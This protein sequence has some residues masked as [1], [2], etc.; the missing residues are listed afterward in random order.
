[1][2]S[3][4]LHRLSPTPWF[5]ISA[6]E[7]RPDA[8]PRPNV[9]NLLES[10][11]RSFTITVVDAPSGFGK[12]TGLA[13]WAR[14][15]TA[16]T[17]WVTVV[18]DHTT[19][20]ELLSSVVA[21]LLEI[22]PHNSILEE[23][24]VRMQEGDEP[25]H[26]L[27]DSLMAALP[28]SETTTVILD[29]AHETTKE[30]LVAVIDPLVRYSRS[31]LRFVVA[32]T[33]DMSTW[34]AKQLANGTARQFPSESLLFSPAEVVSLVS[35][36]V[37][38]GHARA[39]GRRLWEE[40]GGWPV[41][42]QL[43]LRSGHGAPVG[44]DFSDHGTPTVLTDYIEHDILG[45]LEPG[46]RRFVL[47]AT[48]CDRF[49]TA[50]AV[51][52]SGNQNGAA[53]LAECQRRGLFLDSFRRADGNGHFRWHT[54][55]AQSCRDILKRTDPERHA[56]VHRR[57]AE[58]HVDRDPSAAIRHA[59]TTGDRAFVEKTIEASWLQLITDGKAAV[60]ER[61]CLD[62]DSESP[63]LLY[64]RACCRDMAG[65]STG[66]ALL[67]AR[68]DRAADGLS[69]DEALR[70][71]D[72]RRF[73]DLLLLSDYEDI[74]DALTAAEN[75]LS[76]RPLSRGQYT[77]GSFLAAWTRL[78]LRSNPRRAIDLLHGAALSAE[79]SGNHSF[80]RRA[81]ATSALALAFAGRLTLA[82]KSLGTLRSQDRTMGW[83][84]FDG[85]LNSWSAIFIAFWQGDLTTV[86]D[87]ARLLDKTGGP[88][89]SNASMGRV[90]F[91]YAAA[92]L[93][94]HLDEAAIMLRKVADDVIHGLPWPSY[95]CVAAAGL[96]WASG[97]QS[98]AINTLGELDETS[99]IT[100]TL[101]M[102]ADLWRRLGHP[103]QALRLL[104]S[105]DEGF[106]PSF[107]T[108][109]VLFTHAAI[110]W[111][112]G[113]SERAHE[114]L[115]QCLDVIA[116]ESIAQPFVRMDDPARELATAHA[117]WGTAHEPFIAARLAADALLLGP[118]RVPSSLTTRE[119]EIL[120]YLETTMTAAEIAEELHLSPA[121]VRT[122]QRSIYR[123]LGVTTRR[124]AVRSLRG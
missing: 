110:A 123:K 14:D 70:V 32:A 9:V 103:D 75:I 25:L 107:T 96:H 7:I 8:L 6:P 40:T 13:M 48:T 51:S 118:S 66:S 119:R 104:G 5:L 52:I 116:P 83:D 55:F 101:V 50:Q 102:A 33:R 31:R 37:P 105:L 56:L 108:G 111:E 124:E 79:R 73:A 98:A 61:H 59:V 92:L 65:D 115:E 53:L 76:S 106:M 77:H 2:S 39:T 89:S 88:V 1:M 62:L 86:L 69:E 57:A 90:Y 85:S 45:N 78:R 74:A 11:A 58:W 38:R 16:P 36:D 67:R 121:T 44:V 29:D 41:A 82:Q 4:S 91:A 120:T 43:L 49:D 47:D 93:G 114:L 42:V 97:N 3:E 10:C 84:P 109:S 20:R 112:R 19:P 87:E 26:V 17:A 46:L 71:N 28:A 64:M 113:H 15:R 18:R 68:A 35:S 24:I 72:V 12:T 63:A 94:T 23:Q 100:T 81:S 122:H 117:A 95:K 60:L 21:S 30:A 80:A 34:L 27:L 22:Y 99:G 54:T